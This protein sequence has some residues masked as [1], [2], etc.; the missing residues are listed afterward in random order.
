M[1]NEFVEDIYVFNDDAKYFMRALLDTGSAVNM[2]HAG[3]VEESGFEVSP[4]RGPPIRDA[5]GPSVSVLGV[6]NIQ[7]HFR[8]ENS[9]RT[10]TLGFVVLRDPPFDIAF[11][12]PF[13]RKAGLLKRSDV[14]LPVAFGHQSKEEKQG[15]SSKTRDAD[16]RN[17]AVKERERQQE[18]ARRD[19]EKRR[20]EKDKERRK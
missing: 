12:R 4:Y 16:D 19:A 6:V 15:Q 14:A 7:F 9:A 17:D 2:I 5:D 10:W 3:K 1:S 18:R 11:G 20:R 8:G 13:I